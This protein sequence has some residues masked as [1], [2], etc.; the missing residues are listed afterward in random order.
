MSGGASNKINNLQE[1]MEIAESIICGIS[2]YQ[3]IDVRA[4]E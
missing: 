3:E 2:Q 1:D 4:H